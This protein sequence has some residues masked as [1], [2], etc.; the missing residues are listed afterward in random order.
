MDLKNKKVL[1]IDENKSEL[2]INQYCQRLLDNDLVLL[3]NIDYDKQNKIYHKY[4]DCYEDWEYLLKNEF[5]KWTIEYKNKLK[6]YRECERCAERRY[7]ELHP[8]ATAVGYGFH[9]YWE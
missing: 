8:D 1:V 2:Y 9:Y 4:L 6:N 7:L 3:S 5:E